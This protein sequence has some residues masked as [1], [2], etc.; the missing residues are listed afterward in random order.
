VF[1]A[2]RSIPIPERSLDE[3]ELADEVEGEARV[4]AC[5]VVSGLRLARFVKLP[6]NVREASS[7]D[8]VQRLSS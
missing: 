2:D 4:T 5:G 3:V 7:V 8:K 6:S 1:G